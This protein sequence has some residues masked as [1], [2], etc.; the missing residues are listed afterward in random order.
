MNAEITMAINYVSKLKP[1]NKL[2]TTAFDKVD[3]I[4]YD[5]LDD[6]CQFLYNNKQKLYCV[7]TLNSESQN[8]YGGHIPDVF[9]GTIIE[10]KS[11]NL[12]DLE[13][14]NADSI[15]QTKEFHTKEE[16][17]NI[18]FTYMMEGWEELNIQ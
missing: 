5:L 18:M 15:S 6:D 9:S 16:F 10:E 14:E 8:Y 11:N 7:L 3:K 17:E 1:L 4:T 2:I 12:A 13:N